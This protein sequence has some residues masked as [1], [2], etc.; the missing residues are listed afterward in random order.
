MKLTDFT[1]FKVVICLSITNILIF[2]GLTMCKN[3]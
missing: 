3:S 1:A 2:I